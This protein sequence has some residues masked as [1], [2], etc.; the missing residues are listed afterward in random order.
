MCIG[1]KKR[2][3]EINQM[4]NVSEALRDVS[5]DLPAVIIQQMTITAHSS[6]IQFSEIKSYK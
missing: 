5:T 4:R 2:N 6:K 3:D 1:N